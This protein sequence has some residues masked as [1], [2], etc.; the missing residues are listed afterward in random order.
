MSHRKSISFASIP[1]L[2]LL[3]TGCGDNST[4]I[5]DAEREQEAVVAVK[6]EIQTHL[7]ELAAAVTAL[8][9]AAPAPDADGW[10][11]DADKA[12]VD[13]MRAEWKKARIAYESVEGALAVVFPQ[14]DFVLDA[15]YDAFIEATPDDDLF[16][17]T[18]VTGMHAVE[19]ILWANAIPPQVLAFESALVNYQPA[20]F[21]RTQ[22]EATAFRDKLCARLVADVESMRS[23][24]K[25]LALD[26]P[27]A[28][29]GAMGS[30][31]EQREKVVKAAT[32][33]EE[34]R[35]AQFTLADMRANVAAGKAT[36]AAFRDWLLIKEGGDAVDQ[37]VEQGF[38]ALD[39]GYAA[40]SGDSLPPVPEGWSSEA[41]SAE[42]L[43]TPF[44]KLFVIVQGQAEL[45]TQGSLVSSMTKAEQMLGAW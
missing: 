11:A 14:L 43:E 4:V 9:K 28:Y 44:G 42:L 21:P 6:A 17:D 16:D 8:Q 24:W 2:A 15:R 39:A 19:R 12:A 22:D 34:S 45:D 18:G 40:I 13:A 7:D 29:R 33:E 20:T 1:L 35:Y 36:Y 25:T 10:S 27:A 31:E 30:M 26:A 32:G 41:P 23:Q 37:A 38:A 5:D 3:V